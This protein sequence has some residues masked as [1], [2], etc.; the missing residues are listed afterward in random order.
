MPTAR[1][2]N[3]Q[4]HSLT[5]HHRI[6]N[7]RQDIDRV[8]AVPQTELDQSRPLPSNRDHRPEPKSLP[9][10]QADRNKR[11]P[12]QKRRADR[13]NPDSLG[14]MPNSEKLARPRSNSHRD[15]RT[16][17][18]NERETGRTVEYIPWKLG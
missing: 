18:K 11:N 7:P 3:P 2:A 12:A 16:L 17:R 5:L 4:G 10:Q 8:L 15:S 13:G 9:L 14:A 6:H 1:I